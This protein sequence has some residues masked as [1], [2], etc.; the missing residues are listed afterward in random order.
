MPK[1]ITAIGSEAFS[2]CKGL[3]EVIIP[4]GVTSI[5]NLTFAFCTDLVSVELPKNITTIG[6]GAFYNCVKLKNLNI[7]EG[8]T[9]IESSAFSGCS[10][11][12]DVYY[13]GS[14]GQW[15]NIII[16]QDNFSRSTI[17]F[18]K[19]SSISEDD[20]T[21]ST[22]T[23]TYDGKAKKPSVTV[24]YGTNTLT[25]GIDYSVSYKD[26][27]GNDVTSPIN[28]G[29]YTV[30]VTGMGG[31]DGEVNIDFTI[32]AK[33]VTPTVTLSGN[34]YTYNGKVRK[35]IV[36]VKAGTKT[37]TADDYTVKY[38]TNK[39]V[40]R[41]YVTVTLKG[42]YSG[43]K[44][45]S[46]VINPKGTAV[47]TLTAASK[48]FTAKWTKQSEK[49]S[50]SVITGYQIQYATDKAFTKN[51][52]TITVKGYGTTG[53]KITGLKAKTTYYVRIRTY[54]TVGGT[55]YY[56]AWSSVRGIKTK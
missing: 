39:D 19:S 20:V 23:F 13:A 11:L 26:S 45:A 35:P 6:N 38:K 36:T 52:K 46:F 49:M 34:A 37:L 7:P 51:K 24:M 25:E 32:K 28:T 15:D 48:A 33:T 56:S 53:K 10:S 29:T 47:S 22:N 5:G 1:S 21:I 55:N 4:D 30:V 14:K 43:T 12:T 41:A 3:T 54:K 17:H 2:G 42:N 8:V 31:Y 50:T 44:S 16:G 18:A 40:G 27:T 9:T